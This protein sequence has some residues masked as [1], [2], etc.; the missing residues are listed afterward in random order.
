MKQITKWHTEIPVQSLYTA[1]VAGQIFFLALKQRGELVATRCLRCEQVY[2]PARLFCERC[3]AELTEQVT[4]KPEGTI[5]SF[6]CLYVDR[7]GG[8][9]RPPLPLALVQLDGATSVCLHKLL[10][11]SDPGQITIGDRVSV[12]IKP[13]IECTGSILDIVG[14]RLIGGSK[15]ES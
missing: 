13:P 2:F 3:F 4:L 8:P 5:Q 15:N 1:G 9:L 7:D 11:V 14:F 6:T 10:D 12:V